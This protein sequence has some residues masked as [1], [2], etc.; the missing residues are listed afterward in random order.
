MRH[1]L[2]MTFLISP[3]ARYL[4]GGRVNALRGYV[5]DIDGVLLRGKTVLQGGLNAMSMLYDKRLGS[6]NAPVVFLTNGGGTTE[7]ERASLLSDLLGVSVGNEQV[8]LSHTPMRDMIDRLQRPGHSVVTVGGGKCTEVAQSYGYKDVVDIARLGQ[9]QPSATPFARYNH[10]PPATAEDARIA[11][12][13]VSTA[14][15]MR[16]SDD[17]GRDLQLLVDIVDDEAR[18][19]PASVV[20]A[21]PDITFPNEYLKP[22]LAGG[23]LRVALDAVLKVATAKSYSAI[24]LGKPH[25]VN[26]E[27]AEAA[28]VAQARY[29][30]DSG[31][32]LGDF[33]AIYMIGDNPKSDIRGANARGS[34]WRSVLVR[35]GNFRGL[36]NDEK[37]PASMVV[38]DAHHAV[39][40]TL[41]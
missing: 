11:R 13:P 19:D 20:F 21:N 34:P 38:D 8:I 27:A 26:Y 36:A 37:D 7:A 4:K 5:F 14:L 40:N 25:S 31:V 12:L 41:T 15:V 18:Q 29:L 23:C 10:L 22:R 3:M 2:T 28:L 9:L 1:S 24:Q 33:D 17:F 35:T 30:H 16:D 39:R 6:W 32:G